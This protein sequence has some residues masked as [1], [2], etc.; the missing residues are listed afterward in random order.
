MKR[1]LV[2]AGAVIACA[3]ACQ[4]MNADTAQ[5]A[6]KYTISKST[7]PC[8]SAYIRAAG[9]NSKSKN[10]FTI[11]SYLEKLKKQGGGTL[12]LK[13]GTYKICSTLTVP[14]NVTIQLKNGVVLK[15]TDNTGSKALKTGSVM[16]KL[17]SAKA[18][19]Y[20]GTKKV[21]ITSNKKATIDLGKV[22]NAVAIDMGHNYNVTVSNIKFRNK[23]AGTYIN[24]AG[25]RTVKV[26]NC[27]FQGDE[28]YTGGS[29]QAAVMVNSY[30]K[31]PCK[32]VKIE[33]N[34]FSDLE[35]GIRTTKYK[36]EIYAESVSIRNNKFKN[37]TVSAVTGKMWTGAVMT[38]NTIYRSDAT[39]GTAFAFQL[40][41]M[42]EPEISANTIDKCRTPIY[43]GRASKIDNSIS[44]AKVASMENNT[45]TDAVVYYVIQKH[46][47]E[48]RLLYF[49]DK[50]EKDFR[51][52]PE[53]TP[54]RGHY[55]DTSNY[56]ANNAQAKTYYMFR[57]YMEQLEYAGGGTI[58]VA[59]GTYTLSH[60]V[61]IPS[62]VT[63][64]FEDGV[65]IQKVKAINTDMATN[66]TMF[67]LVPPSKEGIKNSIG[68]YNGSQ[69]VTLQGS[70]STILDCAYTLNSM[71]VVMGHA[72]NITIRNIAFTN[73]NG[74]HFIELN[75]SKNVTIENCSFTDFKIYNNKSHK[76]A[77]NIDTT[78]ANN[79][80][81]NYEWSNHDRTACDTVMINNCMFTNMGVAVGSHTYSVAMNDVNTQVYHENISIQ[82]CKVSQTYNAGIRMLNW[83]NAVIKNNEFLGIQGIEDNKG[84]NYT[85]I[86]VKGA[87]NPT[88]TQNKFDKGGTKKNYAVIIYEK[89]QPAVEGAIAAG[90]ADTYSIL[91]AENREAL[92]E[93][94]VTGTC[95]KRFLTKFAD[96]TN[97]LYVENGTKKNPDNL[98]KHAENASE[99]DNTPI[100]DD[101]KEDATE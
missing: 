77:I 95:Y 66:K 33:L 16:F 86:L 9:Y 5:A 67:E 76:E 41:S 65:K 60:S 89:T 1:K 74:S 38:G 11:K 62:N 46:D 24:I 19:D 61:C 82:D 80:G 91:S 81:F 42:T 51:I 48:S 85:C 21:V 59:A 35:N 2:I 7:K 29:Y 27:T 20:K 57:S 43:F 36:K 70:G 49:K 94:T 40:Y 22:K 30:N 45:V 26:T 47:T 73:E 44:S 58:T 69:N 88:I 92:R 52:T 8:N 10:Y 101:G 39:K 37:M 75:S 100:T 72:Q 53:T 83:R 90:Y 78:D 18:K 28:T 12:V 34:T 54:Y 3:A 31:T 14:S 71:A 23:N 50:N 96:G 32:N 84:Y 97:D 98:F 63:V 56:T 15:K 68:G 6:K 99:E 64:N 4:M 87:V 55:E 17:T 13:K 93:N 25:S 79:N